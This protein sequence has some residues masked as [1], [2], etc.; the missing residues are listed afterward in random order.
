M[1][2]V[3]GPEVPATL[4]VAAPR[5]S[6]YARA[7]R[8]L[9]AEVFTMDV[10]DSSGGHL[11]GT[12]YPGTT[13]RLGTADICRVVLAMDITGDSRETVVTTSSRWIAQ[14]EMAG[15]EPGVCEENRQEVMDRLSQ[16]LEPPP[17]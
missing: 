11:T 5:D 3:A 1:G 17:Q 2:L 4:T 13:A 14:E 15:K 7:R 10:V 16:S 8:G 6:T 12:R 9:S